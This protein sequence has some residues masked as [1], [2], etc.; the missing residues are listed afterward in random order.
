MTQSAAPGGEMH[1]DEKPRLGELLVAMGALTDEQL[2][3]VLA[4]QRETGLPLGR[5][6]VESGHVMAHTVAMALAD[7]HGG[8]LRTEYGFATGHGEPVPVKRIDVDEPEAATAPPVL[9]LADPAPD[10]GSPDT[11]Q[12]RADLAAA[13]ATIAQLR[14]DHATILS[15]AEDLRAAALAERAKREAA[16]AA[17]AAGPASDDSRVTELEATVAQLRAELET[18]SAARADVEAHASELATA[19]SDADRLGAELAAASGTIEQLRAELA[20]APAGN[21]ESLDAT[22]QQLRAELSG[23]IAAR[24]TAEAV[25]DDLRIELA[26]A[27]AASRGEDVD[28]L[29]A[30]LAEAKSAADELRGQL[31]AAA[32]ASNADADSHSIFFNSVNGYS[33]EHMPGPPPPIGELVVIDGHPHE[34]MRVGTALWQGSRVACAFLEPK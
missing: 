34:V 17:V 12:L 7:Q 27:S 1:E 18:A 22:I 33:Y 19:R 30:E 4:R 25:A 15:A 29:R 5:M 6:L 11:E 24:E 20:A 16:E 23:A 2:R 28:R 26:T 21:D 10:A 8:L 31:A 32:N 3:E 9:R 14:A 13:E